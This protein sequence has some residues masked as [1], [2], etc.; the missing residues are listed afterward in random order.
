MVDSAQKGLEMTQR[1]E[2]DIFLNQ[3][4]V[5]CQYRTVQNH[6]RKWVA[7]IG[8]MWHGVRQV[9]PDVVGC[10]APTSVL[11]MYIVSRIRNID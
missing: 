6:P 7:L 2:T 11:N 1:A 10:V 9:V 8:M 3:A 5:Q 4:L